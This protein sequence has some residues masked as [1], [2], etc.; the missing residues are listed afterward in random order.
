VTNIVLIESSPNVRQEVTAAL[1]GDAGD[2]DLCEVQPDAE[3]LSRRIRAALGYRDRTPERQLKID[4]LEIDFDQQRVVVQGAEVH[5]TPTEFSLLRELASRPGGLLTH[6]QL[7]RRVWG[8]AYGTESHYLRVYV[9]QL[10]RKLGDN[11]AQPRLIVTEPGI[12]YRW[13]GGETQ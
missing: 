1:N 7:L 9:A 6:T 10:R 11:A 2:L 3:A 13:I 4:G 5:L 12:G 8:P